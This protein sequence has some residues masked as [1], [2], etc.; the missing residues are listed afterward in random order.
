MLLQGC[1]TPSTHTAAMQNWSVV[2]QGDWQRSETKVTASTS[3]GDSL[4]LSDRNHGDVTFSATASSTNREASLAIRM[5]DAANGYLVVFVP[6]GISWNNGVG[7]IWFSKRTAGRESSLGYY[8]RPGFPSLG[9][10]ARLSVVAAGSSF[11]VTLNG[12][13]ILSVTDPAYASGRIGFRIYGDR[14]LP[15]SATFADIEVR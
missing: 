3:S 4:L 6:D 2:G 8:H 12:Q 10:G 5:Q 9:Q 13:N 11:K 1:T 14:G 15:C 7:G